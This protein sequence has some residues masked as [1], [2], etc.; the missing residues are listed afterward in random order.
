[1]TR[2]HR[3][4]RRARSRITYGARVPRRLIVPSRSKT[5]S[6]ATRAGA[7]RGAAALTG[8][9]PRSGGAARGRKVA[10]HV[11]QDPAVAE[12]LLLLGGVDPHARIEFDGLP[13]RDR[14]LH[15]YRARTSRLP[16]GGAGRR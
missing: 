14:R 5:A 13:A 4:G 6:P 7:G 2:S 8:G 16:A 11:V 3:H 10:Q 9:P 1:M 12:V 15:P